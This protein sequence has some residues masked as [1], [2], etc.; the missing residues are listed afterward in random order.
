VGRFHAGFIT[1]AYG[2]PVEL[3]V[4]GPI[5]PFGP[6]G[7]V[8]LTR[9]KERALLAAL[10]LF[11]GRVVS[12]DRLAEAV[13]AEGRPARSKK[14][15][16]I[17]VQRLRVELGAGVIETRSGG[18]A[19][20]PGVVV[21][22]E[23]FERE[24]REEGDPR[25]LRHALA[26]WKGEPYVD[27]GEWAPAES[28]RTRLGEL[29]DQALETCLALEI[30]AG[31][32]RACIAE[33]EVMVA[34]RPLRERRW[35]LLMTA[36][37]GAGRVADAL[38]AYQRARKVFAAE[39]GID[40][41][42]EL[43]RLEEQILLADVR[44]SLP[45]NLPRQLTSFVGRE[46]GIEE[47]VG[48]V[49]QRWLVTL[50]G[51]GGVG[52]TRLALQ[53]AAEAVAEFPD[54][55]W[56]CD[57][58]PISDP[59]GVWRA[60]AASLQL[61]PAPGRA[62][63]DLVLEYL[64]AKRLLLVVDNCEHLLEPAA[65]AVGAIGQRCAWVAVLAT[66]RQ[67]LAVAGEQVIGVPPLQVPEQGAA[68]ATVPDAE[69]MRLFCDRARHAQRDFILDRH[70]LNAVS[71]LCRRLDGLPLAIEL[72]ATQVRSL[73][74]A[75]LVARLDQR[76][77]LLCRASPASLG[78]HQTLRTTIDWSYHLLTDDE[79]SAL[80]RLSAF[81]GGFDL[82][83]A[84]AVLGPGHIDGGDPT[85]LLSQLVDKSLVVA[86]HQACGTRY[87]LLDTI[88]QYA[89]EQ[90]DQAGE[91]VAVRDRH[92]HHY[93]AL[94]EQAGPHLRS[95]DQLS[96]A[97]ALAPYV[98]NLRAAL[99]WATEKSR[100][101][102]ALRLVAALAVTGLPIGWTAFGWA[103]TATT[104]RGATGHH[105]FPAV[106]AW[107]A[108]DAGMNGEL[109]QAARRVETAEA[110]QTALGTSH[111]QV[112]IAGAVL[113]Y[114]RGELEAARHQAEVSLEQARASGDPFETVNALNLL[115]GTL[116]GEPAKGRV[117]AQEA[118]HLA[119]DAG[120]VSLLPLALI[121]HLG[122]V[123]GDDPALELALHDE[124]IAT[125]SA[126]GDKN[127]VAVMVASRESIRPARQGDWPSVL[128]A[129]AD[130]AGQYV[131]STKTTLTIDYLQNA[132]ITFTALRHFE[133]GAVI[134]GFA[135]GHSRRFENPEIMRLLTATDKA[136]V[137]ALGE[138][139]L[140][141][142]KARGSALDL[143]GA[144]TYLRAEAERALAEHATDRPA[145]PRNAR[146]STVAP[147][148]RKGPTDPTQRQP[149]G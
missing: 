130:A 61:A 102:P 62:L 28:E 48:L 106:A 47:L 32:G 129:I 13:W 110:T 34:E 78:R 74:P 2:R 29:R 147:T 23:L 101:D 8:E 12:T 69:A 6:S 109:E 39:L 41:G 136:L 57:L 113:A 80:N 94:A 26:R 85:P 134:L 43:R 103:A 7:P 52:K 82:A 124:I 107:A 58:A 119:R 38:G 105:L 123:G 120:L 99:D 122:F 141:Q 40:P 76:L 22:D 81:A 127:L 112:Y 66:S 15:L 24:S 27:L 42:P 59:G 49:Q 56:L 143:P 133:P 111:V 5:E 149:T 140:S 75:D 71:E 126:L 137:N 25:R 46:R 93:V 118:V 50:T 45:G 17:H 132:A 44:E 146:Q 35:L 53:V 142:L 37:S 72:A 19:L 131:G 116:F 91:T 139:L 104:I 55:A 51:V 83:G 144:V 128:R 65:D 18:Y 96:W 4:F 33:L 92:M 70:N 84:E 100:P 11:H 77:K 98:D 95:R 115:A 86:D 60:L 87:R 9:A 20:A 114:F 108:I 145:S 79:R 135:D 67:G 97:A 10:A 90:L 16:Q 117:A 14:A 3:G 54:G 63:D 68:E 125:A 21:D 89:Q 73:A 30:E 36:L 138:D 1:V 121:T 64:A 88:R 148:A 31:A